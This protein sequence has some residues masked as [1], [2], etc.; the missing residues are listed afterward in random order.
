MAQ[1]SQ[2][3][4]FVQ[5]RGEEAIMASF[6]QQDNLSKLIKRLTKTIATDNQI[7]N[8]E[9]II[10]NQNELE[11]KLTIIN[12]SIENLDNSLNLSGEALTL[13][14]NIFNVLPLVLQTQQCQGL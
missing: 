4:F 6:Q 14:N 1:G 8:N 2:F 13:L 11:D 7:D 12:T 5:E 10:K 3:D 9:S